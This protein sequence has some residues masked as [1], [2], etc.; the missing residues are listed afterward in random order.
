[1]DPRGHCGGG[2]VGVGGGGGGGGGGWPQI[3]AKYVKVQV[4]FWKN[5]LLDSK[6][7]CF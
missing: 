5:F 3:G 2:G 4:L 1:M 7:N 6:P